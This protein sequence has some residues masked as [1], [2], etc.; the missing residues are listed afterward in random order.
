MYLVVGTTTPILLPDKGDA[1][2]NTLDNMKKYFWNHH[3]G[4]GDRFK[5]GKFLEDTES[6]LE[7]VG[8][9]VKVST[10]LVNYDSILSSKK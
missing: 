7:D 9:N 1:R 10:F 8:A 4:G 2:V 5:I 6:Y 3:C